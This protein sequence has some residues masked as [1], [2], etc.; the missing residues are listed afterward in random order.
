M[1]PIGAR[2]KIARKEV[3]LS[4]AEFGRRVGV[5]NAHISK[6]ESGKD[7]PSESL[8]KVIA[9]EYGFALSWLKTGAVPKYSVKE[10]TVK[11]IQ[12]HADIDQKIDMKLNLA[13]LNEC[14]KKYTELVA[15]LS[16]SG[17]GIG[18][19]PFMSDI[20]AIAI[21]NHL[22]QYMF[23]SNLPDAKVRY[24]TRYEV[25]FPDFPQYKATLES[26]MKNSMLLASDQKSAKNKKRPQ[27]E[28]QGQLIIE[29]NLPTHYF[30]RLPLVGQVAAGLP[31]TA[32]EIPGEFITVPAELVS[33]AD[34]FA[35][36][37]KGESMINAGITPGD[38]LIVHRQETAENGDIVVAMINHDEATVKR[39]FHETDH[40]RLQPEN[41]AMEPVLATDVT[42]IGRVINVCKSA[43][44]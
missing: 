10:A 30:A 20:T 19:I 5:T 13:H 39:F 28:D 7:Q 11:L 42:I 44:Q 43:P 34:C 12:N 33:Q 25:A 32:I 9:Y 1:E 27:S 37:V 38:I 41:N 22:Q 31:N 23:S 14:T 40:I 6:I 8:L 17:A 18:V 24:E 26:T 3:G 15:A 4:Q 2:I 21:V 29:E 35:L 36:K 16:H